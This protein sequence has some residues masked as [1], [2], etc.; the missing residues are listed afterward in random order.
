[1]HQRWPQ[2]PR[3]VRE[4]VVLKGYL[5]RQVKGKQEKLCT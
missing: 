4:I 5:A 1:V 3:S 2:K